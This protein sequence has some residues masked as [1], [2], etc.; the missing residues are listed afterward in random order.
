MDHLKII[1]IGDSAVGKSSFILQYMKKIFDPEHELT[2]GVE[3]N[4]MM[5][6]VTDK[7]A[8]L[9]IFDTAGQECFKSVTR[10][11]YRGSSGVILMYD[12]TNYNTFHSISNWLQ[13]IR[14]YTNVHV[15]IILIGNKNDISSNRQVTTKEGEEFAIINNLL[16]LETSSRTGQNVD[17]SFEM[18]VKQIFKLLEENTLPKPEE[19]KTV[20]ISQAPRTNCCVVS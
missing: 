14:T 15:P 7:P 13:E 6:E 19:L 2:V 20:A 10:A 5:I 11:Y 3:F 17:L 8:K 9:L 4:S 1:I 18:L 16:F 12:V